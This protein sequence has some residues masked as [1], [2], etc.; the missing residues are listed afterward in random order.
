MQLALY[1]GH[2][3]QALL[4]AF[5]NKSLPTFRERFFRFKEKISLNIIFFKLN[6]RIYLIKKNYVQ[7]KKM[8][9]K[10]KKF[11]LTI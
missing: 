3:L 10:V 8:T 7:I 2:I 6:K 11:F 9:F 1:I 4:Q 5:Y